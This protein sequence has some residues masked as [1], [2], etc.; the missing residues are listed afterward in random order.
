MIKSIPQIGAVLS[1]IFLV[2]GMGSQNLFGLPDCPLCL[3]QRGCLLVIFTF[4]ALSCFIQNRYWQI[5]SYFGSLIFAGVGFFLALKLTGL[6]PAPVNITPCQAD[7]ETQLEMLGIVKAFSAA[8]AHGPHCFQTQTWW[9][10][11]LPLLSLLGFSGLIGL[12]LY[13][14]LPKK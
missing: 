3:L 7:F 11:T 2:V 9:G 14:C 8:L 5:I 13:G 12:I 6:W 4:L 1:L 10:H